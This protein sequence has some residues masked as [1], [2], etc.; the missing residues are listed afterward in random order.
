MS[1]STTSPSRSTRPHLRMR[2]RSSKASSQRKCSSTSR[3]TIPQN[4]LSPKRISPSGANNFGPRKK[5]T[6]K[7]SMKAATTRPTRD[8]TRSHSNSCFMLPFF[9]GCCSLSSH[10]TSAAARFTSN[11]L[12]FFHAVPTLYSHDS[13]DWNSWQPAAKHIYFI[14]TWNKESHPTI[15]LCYNI[16]FDVTL[17]SGALSTGETN[18]ESDVC[19]HRISCRRI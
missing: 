15:V 14:E 5:L 11:S 1:P 2:M 6:S 10:A 8:E 16:H 19:M 7:T 18:G 4:C 9:C 13:E 17:R 3:N 12:Y